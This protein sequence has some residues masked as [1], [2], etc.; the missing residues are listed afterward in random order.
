MLLLQMAVGNVS[1]T[2]RHQQIVKMMVAVLGLFIVLAGPWH[3]ADLIL[4]LGGH[5]GRPMPAHIQL[6]M[7]ETV[8]LL[9][10]VNGWAMPIVYTSFNAGI[11]RRVADMLT[12]GSVRSCGLCRW[13]R[14]EPENTATVNAGFS[15][16]D[17]HPA[18]GN[19]QMSTTAS[20]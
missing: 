10:F 20:T 5:D 8:A 12:C 6:I 13:N 14:V 11:R 7:R 1:S 15:V 9:M 4:D 3:V 18:A 2:K 16:A 17:S 19:I